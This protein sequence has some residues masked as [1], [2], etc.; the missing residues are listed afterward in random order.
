MFLPETIFGFALV[1]DSAGQIMEVITGEE[2]INLFQVGKNIS[3][4]LTGDSQPQF[5]DFLAELYANQSVLGW[6]M[7]FLL[8]EETLP[9]QISAGVMENGLLIVGLYQDADVTRKLADIYKANNL[10][11][12]QLWMSVKEKELADNNLEL[13]IYDQISQMN[14]ELVNS[15]ESQNIKLKDYNQKLMDMATKDHL[16]GAFNR[17]Y[18]HHKIQEEVVKAARLKY[19]LVLLFIDF[20]NFKLVNDQY[21][22][23]LGDNLL[24]GFAQICHQML[25]VDFDILFRLGGDEFAILLLNCDESNALQVA[26]RIN[27]KVSEITDVSSLSYGAVELL[28]PTDNQEFDIDHYAKIADQR[29]YAFKEKGKK[30]KT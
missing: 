7:N 15:I 21:G 4:Y 3:S 5:L 11:L 24:R 13:S 18:F 25:R 27:E 19:K 6:T 28:P 2:K 20:N 10:Q 14:Y 1:C 26:A 8:Q 16:T 12:E 22:H 9:I 30:N 17:H 29:M 23:D